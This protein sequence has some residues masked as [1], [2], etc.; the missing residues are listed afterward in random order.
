[1][2]V[3]VA[4]GGDGDDAAAAGGDLLDVRHATRLE[5]APAPPIL[6][7]NRHK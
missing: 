4:F 5:S 3:L 1:V 7:S 6:A 2:D